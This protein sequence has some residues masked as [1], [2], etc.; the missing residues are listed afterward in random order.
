MV[1]CVVCNDWWRGIVSNVRFWKSSLLGHYVNWVTILIYGSRV[2]VVIIFGFYDSII[3]GSFSDETYICVGL[4]LITWTQFNLSLS[5]IP[6]ERGERTHLRDNG[7]RE[8][9]SPACL[10]FLSLPLSSLHALYISLSPIFPIPDIPW[11]LCGGESS[12]M[13]CKW[14][15]RCHVGHKQQLVL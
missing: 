6:L 3:L 10:P 7:N 4:G 13:V 5:R 8:K 14:H 1:F 11:S 12:S 2:F 15:H 9:V